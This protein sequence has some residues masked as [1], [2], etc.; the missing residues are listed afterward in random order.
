MSIR[1]AASNTIILQLANEHWGADL[2]VHLCRNHFAILTDQGQILQ[3]NAR[4]QVFRSSV[5]AAAIVLFR[6]HR[7]MVANENIGFTTW[8]SNN[9]GLGQHLGLT[10]TNERIKHSIKAEG[11]ATP[12]FK[13][14]AIGSAI[15]AL[16][17]TFISVA[18]LPLGNSVPGPVNA[19]ALIILLAQGN[20]L[21]L[22][23]DLLG[24]DIQGL[25]QL[26]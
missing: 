9:M 15:A 23:R 19:Q 24:S 18:G 17:G 12:E 25:K 26:L 14:A 3:L 5:I 10:L 21:G 22:Q 2:S 1:C 8:N 11:I 6:L 7:N 13:I 16:L 20:N 4:V